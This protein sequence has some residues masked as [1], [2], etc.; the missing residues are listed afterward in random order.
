[1]RIW[2]A[3]SLR[4][5]RE[6]VTS[7]VFREVASSCLP[8]SRNLP[9]APRSQHIMEV[10]IRVVQHSAGPE[11]PIRPMLRGDQALCGPPIGL[12]RE[13]GADQQLHDRCSEQYAGRPDSADGNFGK[14]HRKQHPHQS[15]E[16]YKPAENGYD[17][18]P[19]TGPNIVTAHDRKPGTA[20]QLPG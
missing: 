19:A 4:D 2:K 9:A 13:K 18:R 15:G 10:V 17:N 8:V 6:G 20:G 11:V 12:V 16:Q 1:L 3:Q 5:L 14:L 7:R